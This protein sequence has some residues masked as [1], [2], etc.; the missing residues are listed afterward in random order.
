[1]R[2]HSISAKSTV[3]QAIICYPKHTTCFITPN[4]N[5][6]SLIII[7]VPGTR[8]EPTNIHHPQ[9]QGRAKQQPNKNEG[10]VKARVHHFHAIGIHEGHL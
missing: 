10:E 2:R 5:S 7:I 1:M 9:A 6:F 4:K 8:K 3:R